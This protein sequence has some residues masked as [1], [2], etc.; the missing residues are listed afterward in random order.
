MG[1]ATEK[2]ATGSPT[3]PHT[4]SRKIR[5]NSSG[6]V[7]E[8]VYLRTQLPGLRRTR[9]P[10]ERVCRCEIPPKLPERGLGFLPPHVR[11]SLNR[12]SNPTSAARRPR[13]AQRTPF[14]TAQGLAEEH[15]LADVGARVR[16]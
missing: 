12:P 16:E 3:R 6:G 11:H 14:R 13:N 2:T 10:H 5:R 9:K 7:I 8:E 1:R 15:D 4:A